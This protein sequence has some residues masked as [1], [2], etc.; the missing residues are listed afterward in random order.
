[1]ARRTCGVALLAWTLLMVTTAHAAAGSQPLPVQVASSAQ[2]IL[3]AAASRGGIELWINRARDHSPISGAGNVTV[4]LDGRPVAV[5]A[6]PGGT[7]SV[8]TRGLAGGA[9]AIEVVVAHDGIR[10]LLT[11]T[12]AVPS[13]ASTLETLE[14]HST[15]AW[16]VLNVGVLL[17]AA[18]L[19]SRRKKSS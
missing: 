7:Y 11:G 17:L 14:K 4:R 2:L 15:W 5:T 19:I 18:R 6:G 12:V 16:W 10:E 13:T 3:E 1:M 9:H 8:S